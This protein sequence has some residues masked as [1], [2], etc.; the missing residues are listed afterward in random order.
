MREDTLSINNEQCNK[1]N[2]T[3]KRTRQTE[4]TKQ[5]CLKC[6]MANII[7]TVMDNQDTIGWS[8]GVMEPVNVDT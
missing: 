8:Q 6:D 7:Q 1:Q 5:L 4:H 3:L 2:M